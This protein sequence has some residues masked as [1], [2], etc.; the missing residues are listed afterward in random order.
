MHK[1]KHCNFCQSLDEIDE[2]FPNGECRLVA[3]RTADIVESTLCWKKRQQLEE[4]G[5]A[6]CE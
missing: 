3:I 6:S 1:I 5:E 4:T 2:C